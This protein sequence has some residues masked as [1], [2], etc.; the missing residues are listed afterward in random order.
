MP[1]PKTKQGLFKV[2]VKTLEG[3][4]LT[5]TKVKGYTLDGGM[6][7]FTDSLKKEVKTFS[8]SQC[9]IQDDKLTETKSQQSQ[10][11]KKSIETMSQQPQ[12]DK[13][14]ESDG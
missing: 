8:T 7:S 14:E 5:F 9:E 12:D 4:I 10:D 2:K 3:R 6:I 11:D 13:P 1:E